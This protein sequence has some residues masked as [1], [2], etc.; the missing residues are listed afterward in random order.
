MKGFSSI[1]FSDEWTTVHCLSIGWASI[2]ENNPFCR[3]YAFLLPD[4]NEFY[5]LVLCED[6]LRHI[7]PHKN[8]SKQIG[9]QWVKEKAFFAHCLQINSKYKSI[10]TIATMPQ[11]APVVLFTYCLKK[12]TLSQCGCGNFSVWKLTHI[13]K[14]R[15]KDNGPEVISYLCK[16]WLFV[17]LHFLSFISLVNYLKHSW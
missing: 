6:L 2:S 11:T 1:T 5:L 7:E 4:N 8:L 17:H 12:L 9:D 14:L 15:C 16:R 3:V 13:W 10:C